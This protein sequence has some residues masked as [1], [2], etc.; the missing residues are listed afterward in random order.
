MELWEWHDFGQKKR[1]DFRVD[2][3]II[4]ICCIFAENFQKVKNESDII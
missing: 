3:D 2:L 4:Y 1:F